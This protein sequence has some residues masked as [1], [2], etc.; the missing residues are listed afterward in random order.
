[1]LLHCQFT[2]NEKKSNVSKF[3][4]WLSSSLYQ[5]QFQI[6]LF[7]FILFLTPL[8]KAH[9][10]LATSSKLLF[11]SNCLKL[12]AKG[13]SFQIS[14]T[15]VKLL[16]LSCHIT[17]DW[18]H[19]RCKFVMVYLKYFFIVS[20]SFFLCIHNMTLLQGFVAIVTGVGIEN[21]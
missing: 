5:R 10:I 12:T 18:K 2:I 17:V 14:V 21:P 13:L 3:V 9:L 4:A 6:P 15:R 19:Q 11:E 1:M 16:V 7:F 8:N 20:S